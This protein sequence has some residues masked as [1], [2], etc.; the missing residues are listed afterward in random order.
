MR[1]S[2]KVMV[3]VVSLVCLLAC[4]SCSGLKLTPEM[5]ESIDMYTDAV[6]S[7]EKAKG[8]RISVVSVI[9]DDAIEFKT[10]ETTIDFE[11]SVEGD[12]V[13]FER[14][15]TLNGEKTAKYKCDGNKIEVYDFDKEKWS[16]TTDQN[17]E[18]LDV[19]K[20]PLTSLTLFR[21]DSN[22][23]VDTN[24]LTDIKRFTEDEYTVIEFT[25]K[26]ESVSSVM[27]YTKADG[28]VR[29]SAGHT[30]SY[31]LDE[32]GELVKINIEAVQ[33]IITNGTSNKYTTK[34]TVL[35]KR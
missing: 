21:V 13:I 22:K 12:K 30:R 16:D 11:Y 10:T 6:S 23:K 20:N 4:S 34:M 32:K 14:F 29:E 25:L 33:D 5:E 17:K 35:I 9:D 19:K 24:L 3:F 8:G 2:F 7:A 28:I 15:D 26:D 27:S 1:N 18:Y 31:Y